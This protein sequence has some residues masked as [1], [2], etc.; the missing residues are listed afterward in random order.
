MDGDI[1]YTEYQHALEAYD[2]SGEPNHFVGQGPGGKGY[3]KFETV[4]CEKIV[5]LLKSRNMSPGELFQ[6]CDQD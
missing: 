1:T 4:A 3:V 5:D 2:V 6:L